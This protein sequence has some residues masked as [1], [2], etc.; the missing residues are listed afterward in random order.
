MIGKGL[1]AVAVVGVLAGVPAPAAAQDEMPVSITAGVDIPSLYYFRGF[2]Q[3]VDPTFTMWPWID[4]GVPLISEGE[5]SI[6]SATLNVGLWN[7]IHTGSNK[8]DFDGAFYESDIYA[9]LGL[10]FEQFALGVTYTGYTYPAPDFDAIHEIL[11]KVSVPHT[12]AP[13]GLVAYEFI[14]CDGC[15]KGTYAEIGIGPSW[16][17]S[18]EEGAATLTVPVKLGFGLKDY[19]DDGAAF[20]FFSVGGTVAKAINEMVSVKGGVE[21]L[22]LGEGA[23]DFNE[24]SDGEESKTGFVVFG[25]I[26]FAF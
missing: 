7:S 1:M 4:V 24:N 22:A 26:G 13:Y 2:R 18:E 3:E 14:D 6:K 23:E 12:L 17:L 9:T 16:P 10:G 20:G 8:D 5:G 21:V 11:F 15:D 19:Y 25:G